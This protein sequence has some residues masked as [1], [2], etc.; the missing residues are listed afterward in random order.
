MPTKCGVPPAEV[1]PYD[2]FVGFALHQ[3]TKSARVF[4]LSGTA[5]PIL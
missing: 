3:R 1:V 4:T 2:A 5:G